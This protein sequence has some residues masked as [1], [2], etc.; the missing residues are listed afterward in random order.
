MTVHLAPND[1]WTQDEIDFVLEQK[2]Y[3]E[4]KL[5]VTI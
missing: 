1:I 4:M 5:K 2:K 3:D